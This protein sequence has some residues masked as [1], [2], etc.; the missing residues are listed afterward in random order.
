[1]DK[2]WNILTPETETIRHLCD[3]LNCHPLIGSIL[4]SRGFSTASE[5]LEFLTASLK[6][7]RPPFGMKDMDPAVRRLH[8]ALIEKE[9]IIIYGDYDADGVTSTALLFE[10]LRSAGAQVSYFIPHRLHD[11]YGMKEAF[12][13]NRAL[14]DGIGLI[15]TVD[16]GSSDH[17]AV[18]AAKKAGID[19]IVTDHHIPDE[20]LPEATALVNPNRRDCSVGLGSLAGVGVAFYLLIA[21][22][23]YLRDKGYWNNIREPN[24]KSCC[25][26]VALGTIA[27]M[28]P[29]RK[30]NRIFARTGVDVI[31]SSGRPG[32]R[33]LMT[34]SG[35]DPMVA[36]ASD[37]AFRLAPRLNAAGRMDHAAKAV[38]LLTERDPSAALQTAEHLDMLNRRRREIEQ[39]TLNQILNNLESEP[40]KLEGHTLVLSDSLWHE[41]VLGIVASRLVNLYHRPVVLISTAKAIGRGSARSIPGIN[42]YEALKS[43]NRHLTAF[44]GHSTAAGL[45][46]P[47]ESIPGFRKDLETA[48][49]E[50]TVPED[51]LSRLD[52]DAVLDLGD[53]NGPLLDELE[54]LKPFGEGNPEPLFMAMDVA[55]VSTD[56][57]GNHH[58]RMQLVQSGAGGSTPISAMEF[59]TDPDRSPPDVFS[60]IAFRLGWNRWR[61]MKTPQMIIVAY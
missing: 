43:C 10:F 28:V 45:S 23:K 33:A 55:V 11:G 51:F 40:G 15:V 20:P 53:I 13:Q 32:I 16:C 26:L 37:I 39:E 52:I 9:K 19:V 50:N 2:H 35:I 42:L 3:S 22:R 25:D 8:R 18:A 59:N 34:V 47:V 44:G 5:A 49:V 29:M 31:R 54:Y 24:L 46:I 57:V 1:M 12:I 48:V 21:L 27:D 61:G 38:S 17:A 58:R 56:I 36:D 4:A 6:D 60:R 41:G 7:I 14:P 30:E